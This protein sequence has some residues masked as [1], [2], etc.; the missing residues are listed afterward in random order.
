MPGSQD[1]YRE[2]TLRAIE[3]MTAWA[4]GGRSTEFMVE[5]I[6]KIGKEEGQEGFVQAFVGLVNVAGYMLVRLSQVTGKTE[7][8]LLQLIALDC[9]AR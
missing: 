6:A 4:G 1:Q 9:E 7:E 8:E 2:S 5:R 3:L